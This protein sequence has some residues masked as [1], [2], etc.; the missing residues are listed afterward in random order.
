MHEVSQGRDPIVATG[1]SRRE[2]VGLAFIV[3]PCLLYSMDRTVLNLALPVLSADLRPS[4]AQLLWIVDVYGF[5]LAGLLITMGKLGDRWGHRRLLLLGAGLFG[6]A[7][8]LAAVSDTAST[9][10]AAR[11]LLGIA[12]ATLAPSTLSLI[13]VMFVDGRQRTFAVGLWAA[14]YS[15]GGALGPLVGGLMLQHFTWGSVFLIGVPVMLAL[16]AFG[17]ALLPEHRKA[18]DVELDLVSAAL[19]LLAVLLVVSCLKQLAARGVHPGAL[20]SLVGAG[21]AGLWWVRRQRSVASP[22]IDWSVFRA[23]RFSAAFL[24]YALGCFVSVGISIFTAQHLQLV[25]GLSPVAAGLWTTPAVAGFI[26]GSMMAPTLLTRIDPYAALVGGL[27]VAALGLAIIAVL[28]PSSSV[29]ALA[30][31]L[32]LLSGG[33]G[34]VYVIAVDLMVNAMPVER[35]GEAAAVAETGAEL[36]AALGIAVLGALALLF[37]RPR[38]MNQC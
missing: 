7:S 37:I 19:G 2:W 35:A 27:T 38:S 5:L 13:R 14:A 16:L 36:G 24:T 29:P 34:P 22:L 20:A 12:S 30:A 17:P 4:A 11:A 23:L 21:V 3:L 25:L 32:F 33:L 10:I 18:S 9:L 15:V 1:A 8:V 31:G 6:V 28:H 26:I